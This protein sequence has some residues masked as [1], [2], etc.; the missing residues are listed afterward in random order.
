MLNILRSIPWAFRITLHTAPIPFLAA[1]CTTLLLTF[2][3]SAQVVLVNAVVGSVASGDTAAS[4]T[5]VAV[6]GVLVA[7]YLLVQ[8]ASMSLFTMTKARVNA[9]AHQKLNITLAR[10]NPEV[11]SEPEMQKHLRAARESLTRQEIPTQAN[12]VVTLCA[13]V[14]LV[15]LLCAT[16]AGTSLPVAFFVAGHMTILV[17]HRAWTLRHADSI[18]VMDADAIVESGT[19]T[20]LMARNSHFAQL[21]ASQTG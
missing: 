11:M 16:I 7:A 1:V 19:Y 8:R 15:L 9:A 3:P 17:S 18:Y 5:W 2:M 13:A 4:L 21:F 6:I 20:E 10:V 14:A 12:S